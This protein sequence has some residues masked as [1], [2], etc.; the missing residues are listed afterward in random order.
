MGGILPVAI[1][2]QV[3][4]RILLRYEWDKF[5]EMIGCAENAVD[6]QH[7][8]RG[9]GDKPDVF[10]VRHEITTFGSIIA[11]PVKKDNQPM[12]RTA[13][14]VRHRSA[15]FIYRAKSAGSASGGNAVP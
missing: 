7:G 12:V 13:Q 8:G 1:Q 5:V 3:I 11:Q 6:E 2:K 14:S 4:Y 10:F 15:S 9:A